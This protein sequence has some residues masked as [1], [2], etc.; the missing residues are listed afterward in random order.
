M[1]RSKI[2]VVIIT[3]NAVSIIEDCL[4]SVVWADEIIVVDN[5]S[6]DDTVK[7]AKRY[8][9][10]VY[11]VKEDSLGRKKNFA[12]SKARGDWILML[13]S[14]ERISKKLHEEIESKILTSES[15]DCDG[16]HIK[17]LNHFLGK[18]MY[19]GGES[20]FKIR[21]FKKGKGSVTDVPVHEDVILEGRVGYL[22]N[23]I[24][25]YSYRSLSQ[26]LTKFQRYARIVAKEKFNAKEDVNAK[27]LFLYPLHM[28]YA[29]FIKDRG[30]KDNWRGLLLALLFSYMEFLIYFNLLIFGIK[31]R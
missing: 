8:T 11:L 30:Y 4:K 26:T 18:P 17:F 7:I 16:F 27:K 13:D 5:Y 2:S 25:H 19:F 20:Y 1:S 14:D 31:G 22:E 6:W 23:R 12:I 9:N 24:L 3:K 21:L 15:A 28:F 29:R 10:K